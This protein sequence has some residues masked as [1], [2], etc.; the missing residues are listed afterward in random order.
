MI[1]TVIFDMDG[2]IIDS[3]P[4]HLRIGE[5][6]FRELG[7]NIT[8]EEH[9]HFVGR[10]DLW[11]T[12][13]EKYRLDMETDTLKN[14]HQSRFISFL[15]STEDEHPING[16]AELIRSLYADHLTL[17]LASSSSMKYIKTV[18]DKFD[19]AKYFSYRI[20]GADL[21][22]SKP[23]PEIFLKAAQLAGTSPAHSLVI[24]D[25]EHG[26]RAA[27]AAG[28]RCV[29]FRNINSGQQNLEAA[30]WIIDTFSEFD[31]EKYDREH[32]KSTE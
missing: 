10:S 25:S 12:V 32:G 16:V 27:R 5:A 30:D 3:E 24:E 8:R 23:H 15:E 11:E 17:V 7:L 6:M 31:L 26:V 13:K 28:M 22:T 9:L 18:L 2:V 19:L 29:A 1:D 4:V 21:P 20:S 14:I